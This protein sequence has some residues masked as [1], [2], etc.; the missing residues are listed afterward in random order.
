MSEIA[1]EKMYSMFFEVLFNLRTKKSF[2]EVI[3]EI[4]SPVEK[5]MIA[6]RVITMYLLMKNVEYETICHAL[7]ISTSTV[8]K[9]SLL[10]T[11]SPHIKARLLKII[12]SDRV[13]LIF[14]DLIAA[15]FAPGAIGVDWKGAWRRKLD[16]KKKK[17][18]GF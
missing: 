8:A 9:F 6:K 7:K 15:I 1:L 13:K 14:E 17:A 10:L 12:E 3:D 18:M 2:F 4:I 16:K 11:N 5:I